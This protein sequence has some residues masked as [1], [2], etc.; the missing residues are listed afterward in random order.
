[1][2]AVLQRSDA[3]RVSVV[4]PAYN[5]GATLGAAID[6]VLAQSYDDVEVVVVDDGST[7]TTA[8]V[9][10]G[11]GERVRWIS[12]PNAGLAG[13]RNAG[14]AMARGDYIALFD[15]DD[16]CHP[17]RLAVEVAVLDALPH[18]IL[19]SGAFE[20]FDANGPIPDFGIERYYSAIASTHGGLAA[21]YG[22]TR[23]I[24]CPRAASA[25]WRRAIVRVGRVDEA[26]VWGS[27]VH[28][29]TVMFRRSAWIGVGAFASTLRNLAD[30]DWLLRVA[31]LGAFAHVELPL[32]RYR[33]S[34]GQMSGDRNTLH[35]KLDLIDM[36]HALRR[37]DPAFCVRHAKRLSR[38]LSSAYLGAADALRET[39]RSRA[40]R[41]LWA[42]CREHL[43]PIAAARIACKLA[44]PDVVLQGVRDWRRPATRVMR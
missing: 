23:S 31:A 37:R 24:D 42:G 21:L 22:E 19:V 7:D 30:Y 9:L 35:I 17:D 39:D 20:A 43:S 36:V 40:W 34:E 12:Q 13:A 10:R 32:I 29:P 33:L 18:V 6:S 44:L 8:D 3:P 27:F 4:I 38:R 11:Y 26:M 15:A 41:M 1:M 14:L 2:N 25:S 16:L 5:A 28:P